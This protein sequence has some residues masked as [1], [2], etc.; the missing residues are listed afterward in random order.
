MGIKYSAGVSSIVFAATAD[1][2]AY[3]ANGHLTVESRTANADFCRIV[4][5]YI[6]G[7][8]TSS[9]ASAMAVRRAT[10]AAATPTN[11]QPAPY[12]PSS[13]AAVF[14]FLITATTQP[15]PA[16]N[17]TVEHLLNL[18]MNLFGGIVRWVAAPDEEIW[19]YGTATNN[20]SIG[21]SPVTGAGTASAHYVVEEM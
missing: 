1:N 16:V 3:T 14:D 15:T 21:L 17:T 13:Q 7:E 19:F 4:E 20:N 2:V 8:A 9:V 11:R 5:V 12:N 18:G 6:G 10:T